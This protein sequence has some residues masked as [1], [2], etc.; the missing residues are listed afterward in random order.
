[1]LSRNTLGVAGAAILGSA[2]LLATNTASAAIDIDKE[3]GVMVAKET[4]LDNAVTT[5]S[6]TTTKY[7]D[8]AESTTG[9]EYDLMV[10]QGIGFGAG[11]M[12]Y[13]RIELMNMV[14]NNQSAIANANA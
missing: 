12:L 5:P 6:G 13:L 11:A 10:K 8:L 2:A 4:L 14:F 7:Y 9:G 3:T 1:M